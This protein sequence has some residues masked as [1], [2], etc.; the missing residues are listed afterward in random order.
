MVVGFRFRV[1]AWKKKE[2]QDM[3]RRE[4]AFGE[5]WRRGIAPVSGIREARDMGEEEE[6]RELVASWS[7]R[8]SVVI[9]DGLRIGGTGAYEG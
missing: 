9:G 6:R 4:K 7:R 3:G 8:E 5:V 1:E 2:I